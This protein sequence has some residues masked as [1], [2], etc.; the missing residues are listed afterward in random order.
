MSMMP[1]GIRPGEN[2][3]FHNLGEYVFQDLCRD[4]LDAEP[5][6][7]TCEVYGERGQTQDGIDILAY[8]RDGDGIVA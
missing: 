8:R 1:P 3:P 4:L 6:V 5:D 7:D 2:P